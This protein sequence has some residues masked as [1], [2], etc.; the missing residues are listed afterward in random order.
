[1]KKIRLMIAMMLVAAAMTAGCGSSAS[2]T[3]AQ[4]TAA[5]TAATETEAAAG[6]EVTEAADET[7]AEEP[8]II[9]EDGTYSVKVKTDSSMFHLN[10]TVKGRGILTVQD[11]EMM[12]HIT[13]AS[14]G[15]VELYYGTAEEAKADEAG[16]IHYTEDEVTYSDGATEVVYGFDV[17][18][19]SLDREYKVAILGTKGT[20]Y[21]HKMKVTDPQL[22]EE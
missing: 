3:A 20:W 9:P 22:P 6:E 17:P 18:V 7:E 21:D 2:Q 13:L 5:E 10:E 15:I 11:G 14:T 4:T 12:L 8:A 1:M 19:P 16:W